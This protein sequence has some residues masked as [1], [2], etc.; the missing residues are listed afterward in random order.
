[1]TLQ[2]SRDHCK[3]NIEDPELPAKLQLAS[4]NVVSQPRIKETKLHP[5]L[6]LCKDTGAGNEGALN[7]LKEMRDNG[8]TPEQAKTVINRIYENLENAG[9][10]D[11]N[12][13]SHKLFY[14][15]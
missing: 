6:E 2:A 9:I 10:T 13:T 8:L 11:P 15:D 3:I 14:H 7:L 5:I 12:A 1:M 4:S